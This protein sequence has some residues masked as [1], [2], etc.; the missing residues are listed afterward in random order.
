MA[1]Q[2]LLPARA[3]G[4]SG[5]AEGCPVSQTAMPSWVRHGTRKEGDSSSSSARVDGSEL[6][7]GFSA[8]GSPAILH[9]SQPRND[10][11][12]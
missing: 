5:P 4:A 11:D 12:E 3:A 2:P 9:S 7:S 8:K 6:G 1:V 10:Q